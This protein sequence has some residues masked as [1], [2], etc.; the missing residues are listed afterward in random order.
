M[1]NM[2]TF[3]KLRYHECP[4]PILWTDVQ[5][6]LR[7]RQGRH[8]NPKWRDNVDRASQATP[9]ARLDGVVIGFMREDG[10]IEG[11]DADSEYETDR[12]TTTEWVAVRW[13]TG[14]ESVYAVGWNA[15]YNLSHVY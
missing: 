4:N 12:L 13:D 3:A 15:V 10:T 9:K 1:I 5:L 2:M 14:N 11:R 7:V 8:W 6:G